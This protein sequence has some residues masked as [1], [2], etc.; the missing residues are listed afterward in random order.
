MAGSEGG[1]VTPQMSDPLAAN[2]PNNNVNNYK[3]NKILYG[4]LPTDQTLC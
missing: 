2:S 4:L 3:N 1:Q